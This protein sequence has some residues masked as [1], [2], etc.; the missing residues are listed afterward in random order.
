MKQ[1]NKTPDGGESNFAFYLF[2]LCLANRIFSP[3]PRGVNCD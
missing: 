2:I 3:C 1:Y